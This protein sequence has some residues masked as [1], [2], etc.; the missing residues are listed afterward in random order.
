M[1]AR[2]NTTM[3]AIQAADMIGVYR[4]MGWRRNIMWS[5][6]FLTE[7]AMIPGM[8]NKSEEGNE[9]LISIYFAFEILNKHSFHN[10]INEF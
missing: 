10:K 9:I 1:R 7:Y 5:I 6:N 3:T 2:V 4:Q 8:L